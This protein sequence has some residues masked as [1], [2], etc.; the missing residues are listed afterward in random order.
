MVSGVVN[1]NVPSLMCE[2][3]ILMLP[4]TDTPAVTERT[5]LRRSATIIASER[6]WTRFLLLLLFCQQLVVWPMKQQCS[7]RG[8][9][10]TWPPNGINPIAPV[11]DT[12]P[13]FRLHQW[14]WLYL[15]LILSSF[16]SFSNSVSP[17]V[18]IWLLPFCW[19]FLNLYF[20]LFPLLS[21]HCPLLLHKTILC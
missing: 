16:P 17:F 21:V 6:G 14:T 15:N 18:F 5:S 4:L 3:L 2:L 12:Q 10:P 9:P 7:T 8:L 19:F 11:V 13:N 1:S 20:C